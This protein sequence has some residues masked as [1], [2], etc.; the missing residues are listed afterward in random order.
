MQYAVCICKKGQQSNANTCTPYMYITFIIVDGKIKS[1]R[2]TRFI[3]RTLYGALLPPRYITAQRRSSRTQ[4]LNKSTERQTE[5]E[6][7][8]ET[9]QERRKKKSE[10]ERQI[11]RQITEK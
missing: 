10:R 3:Q 8:I 2:Q 6:T 7:D 1:K 4:A 11:R 5:K 9:Y